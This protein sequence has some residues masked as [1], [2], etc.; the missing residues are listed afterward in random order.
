VPAADGRRVRRGGGLLGAGAVALLALG[1]LNIIRTVADAASPPPTPPA[2]AA[3]A[4][5]VPGTAS[6]ATQHRSTSTAGAANRQSMFAGA[7]PPSTP[8]RITVPRV[9]IDAQVISVGMARNG[10]L[11]V[12]P[13]TD[14]LKAGWYDKGP[15]PGENGPAVIDAHVDAVN[16]P[17]RRAAFFELGAVR[18][19][20]RVE[21]TRADGTV[22]DFSVDSVEVVRKRDFP[23]AKV[24][25][26]LTYAGLRLITCGGT[27]NRHAGYLDNVVV[28]A[29]L[30]GEHRA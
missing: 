29:H 24:Y 4:L 6:R 15:T 13:F 14:A 21:V 26:P 7:M 16:L 18:P 23:T 30:S 19:G 3:R 17:T 1:G 8:V 28:Y 27:F 2:S 10:A 5:P 9:G 11:G 22:A 25:G 12:P 20:D